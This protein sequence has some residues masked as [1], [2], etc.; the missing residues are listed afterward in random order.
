MEKT[1]FAVYTAK[2]GK[3]LHA[4]QLYKYQDLYRLKLTNQICE[5]SCSSLE[6]DHCFI[7]QT[8]ES[9]YSLLSQSNS[10]EDEQDLFDEL[11]NHAAAINVNH[12]GEEMKISNK[13]LK[14]SNKV[15]NHLEQVVEEIVLRD[16]ITPERMRLIIRS[17]DEELIE[18][19][20]VNRNNSNSDS[21]IDFNRKLLV[22]QQ[23]ALQNDFQYRYLQCKGYGKRFAQN[24]TG[25]DG[26]GDSNISVTNSYGSNHDNCYDDFASQLVTL[27]QQHQQVLV[28]LIAA[29]EKFNPYDVELKIKE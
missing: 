12:T 8:G 13:L 7:F 24:N 26:E 9:P 11:L 2:Y 1:N 17:V 25:N 14:D 18:R 5:M 29:C 3:I 28:K 10:F 27:R 15:I 19:N 22:W 20:C 21:L 23:N 16:M 4:M 6:K